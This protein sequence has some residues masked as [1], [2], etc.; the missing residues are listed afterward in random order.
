MHVGVFQAL[1]GRSRGLQGPPGASR[2]LHGASGDLGASRNLQPERKMRP[3]YRQSFGPGRGSTRDGQ[4]GLGH[5]PW[6]GGGGWA[7]LRL[8]GGSWM[9]RRTLETNPENPTYKS[10]DPRCLREGLGLGMLTMKGEAA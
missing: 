1:P 9:P 5:P 2:G 4:A 6:R 3:P 8:Q 7:R 10:L